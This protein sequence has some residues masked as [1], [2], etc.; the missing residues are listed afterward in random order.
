MNRE[1]AQFFFTF[2]LGF[3][4]L[5]ALQATFGP[6]TAV[7][8][9]I[10][11]MP[12]AYGIVGLSEWVATRIDD[13]QATSILRSLGK[14]DRERV[15]A[16]L[17]PTLQ[18]R[19]RPGIEQDGSDSSEAGVERFPFPARS[20]AAAAWLH[21]V[22]LAAGV[23]SLSAVSFTTLGH[24][25]RNVLL[26]LGLLAIPSSL[27]LVRWQRRLRT[28]LEV[29]PFQITECSEDGHRIG[30]PFNQSLLL[31]NQPRWRRMV[32]RPPESTYGLRLHYARMGYR[33]L[34]ALVLAN[35]GF[36]Q[37]ANEEL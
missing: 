22:L 9:L 4:G 14:A 1:H 33:R 25:T 35:G 13:S 7:W 17:D 5:R 23:A 30:I 34:I 21:A 28:V 26:I 12:I 29:S 6:D 36:K 27:L 16:E 8:I 37:Q 31:I 18:S 32:L 2:V 20:I 10:F 15:M 11:G 19:L 24:R 3:L